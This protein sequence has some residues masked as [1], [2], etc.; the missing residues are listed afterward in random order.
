MRKKG[1]GESKVVI[2][3]SKNQSV[4][5]GQASKS[6][7]VIFSMGKLVNKIFIKKGESTDLQ[8]CVCVFWSYSFIYIFCE[9]DLEVYCRGLINDSLYAEAFSRSRWSSLSWGPR[10]IKQALFNKG[11]STVNAQKAI[12]LVFEEGK[13]GED[14]E[15]IHGLSKLSMDN[16]VVQ[17]SKQWLRGLEVPEQTR[18]SRVSSTSY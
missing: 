10:Q 3:N 1:A 16:L 17:A 9:F 8:L 12:K 11:V 15:L 2:W 14:K 13:P 7:Y 5:L 18:K 4:A 6:L